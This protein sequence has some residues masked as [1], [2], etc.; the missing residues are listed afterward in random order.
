MTMAM[1]SGHHHA[2]RM[3]VAPNLVAFARVLALPHDEV[4]LMVERELAANSALELADDSGR[5]RDRVGAELTTSAR[6][7][8]M[9]APTTD[10]ERLLLDVAPQLDTADRGVAAY[11]VA[12]LDP[13]GYLD[14]SIDDVAATLKVPVERVGRVVRA[15]QEVGP[16]GICARDVVDGLLLQLTAWEQVPGH[17]PVPVAR[18]ILADHLADLALGRCEVIGAALGVEVA[19]IVGVQEFVRTAL[20]PHPCLLDAAP[21]PAGPV[22]EVVI[23]W[24]KDSSDEPE[25]EVADLARPRIAVNEFCAELARGPRPSSLSAGEF[26]LVCEHVARAEE[27]RSLLLARASTLHRIATVLARRQRAFLRA[28]ASAHVPL[29]RADV[30]LELGVHESTVSRAVRDKHVEL[31]N[32]DVVEMSSFFGSSR[33]AEAALLELVRHQIGP[34]T[35]AE[36][37]RRLDERGHHLSRRSVAKY[38]AR[39]GV[40]ALRTG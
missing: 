29:T 20:T 31:P 21:V 7:A 12:D 19:E 33:S 36:I 18:R 30:A 40:P 37:A 39:L 1:R 15:I 4:Q 23:R 6:A 34:A 35:D 28:G 14:R 10:R 22:A 25:I 8:Q 27:L 26:A 11:L 9:E 3:G 16:P 17:D 13:Y 2:L 38:R 24:A 32:G 5:G